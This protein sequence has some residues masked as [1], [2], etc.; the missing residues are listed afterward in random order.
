MIKTEF[1][2]NEDSQ[3]LLELSMV[4]ILLWMEIENFANNNPWRATSPTYP[5]PFYL[6]IS[7]EQIKQFQHI[8]FFNFKF[9]IILEVDII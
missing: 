1:Q 7:V 5:F 8:P 4:M 3:I 9:T 6:H 2:N